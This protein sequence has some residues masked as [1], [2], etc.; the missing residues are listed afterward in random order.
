M[1]RV[2]EARYHQANASVATMVGMTI[3]SMMT[4]ASSRMRV[5]A[6]PTGPAGEKMESARARDGASASAAKQSCSNARRPELRMKFTPNSPSGP[7]NRSGRIH[8]KD[9]DQFGGA[10]QA[11]GCRTQ[12]LR[13]GR[14]EFRSSRPYRSPLNSLY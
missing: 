10:R 12:S 13:T 4:T 11:Q 14:T 2:F 7:K 6:L 9:D 8:K 3:A 5:S 1:A